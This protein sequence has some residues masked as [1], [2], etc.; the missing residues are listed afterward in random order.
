MT[1]KA[2]GFNNNNKKKKRCHFEKRRAATTQIGAVAAKKWHDRRRRRRR[3]R[4]HAETTAADALKNAV[5][6]VGSCKLQT[7]KQTA[8]RSHYSNQ[9]FPSSYFFCHRKILV[10]KVSGKSTIC[11]WRLYEYLAKIFR[12]IFFFDL[13]TKSFHC[14]RVLVPYD[15]VICISRLRFWAAFAAY[16]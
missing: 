7:G 2:S 15:T 3:R 16:A 9:L 13:E 10:G 4:H 12:L 14:S 5:A 6:P 1:I 11:E 8:M